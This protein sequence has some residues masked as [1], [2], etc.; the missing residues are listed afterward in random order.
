[1]IEFIFTEFAFHFC[2]PLALNLSLPA[3]LVKRVWRE[4]EISRLI[5]E[6]GEASTCF[7][8][9][10]TWLLIVPVRIPNCSYQT[11]EGSA[12]KTSRLSFPTDYSGRFRAWD[13]SDRHEDAALFRS[14]AW[15]KS[16]PDEAE[17]G[18][19]LHVDI[20]LKT[21]RFAILIMLR[22]SSCCLFGRRSQGKRWSETV[23][24]LDL[25]PG[26]RK[27][28]QCTRKSGGRRE[29]PLLQ[30]FLA[31]SL[32]FLLSCWLFCWSMADLQRCVSHTCT[33]KRFSYTCAHLFSDSSPW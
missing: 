10:V 29:Q 11:R 3:A 20:K 6:A 9:A 33:A 31:L 7:S 26:R 19:G 21:S 30:L 22:L 25:C 23:C 4:V 32:S 28:S 13:E 14:G 18:E 2:Q 24:R 1:M 27:Y 16:D 5:W 17:L 8:G 15:G 12:W